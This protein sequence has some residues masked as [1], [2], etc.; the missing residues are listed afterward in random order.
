MACYLWT[1]ARPCILP[2]HDCEFS[3]R[4][5]L[6]SHVARRELRPPHF[7]STTVPAAVRRHWELV[8][9]VGA[10]KGTAQSAGTLQLEVCVYRDRVVER[11]DQRKRRCHGYQFTAV[12][13]GLAGAR[14]APAAS[15]TEFAIDAVLE[16]A[17]NTP[18]SL[19]HSLR[20]QSAYHVVSAAASVL[21]ATATLP[22]C[23]LHERHPGDP[24]RNEHAARAP[25]TLTSRCTHDA[26]ESDASASFDSWHGYSGRWVKPKH[27]EEMVDREGRKLTG[28]RSSGHAAPTSATSFKT[29]LC[30]AA[31]NF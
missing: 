9:S 24:Q 6:A 10:K 17:R 16:Q 27:R 19:A 23:Y 18:D 1:Y 7:R 13:A 11:R 20:T 15:S 25:D 5:P 31:T 22:R 29:E 26:S 2:A 30:C 4:T 8:A 28:D 12:A 21:P 3:P 14:D